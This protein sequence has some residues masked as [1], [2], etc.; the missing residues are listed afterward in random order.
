MEK[1]EHVSAI[2]KYSNAD[3]SQVNKD[4]LTP[5]QLAAKEDA[6]DLAKM[7]DKVTERRAQAALEVEEP[8]PREKR[9]ARMM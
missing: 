6:T 9:S 1:E 3:V 4:G 2:V 5:S 8:P 7:I